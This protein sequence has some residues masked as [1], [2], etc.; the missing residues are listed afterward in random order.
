MSASAPASASAPPSLEPLEPLLE[1]L[2]ELA[3]PE[4]V[5]LLDVELLLELEPLDDSVG[6]SM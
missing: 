2:L 3:L 4:L 5:L 1:L 6:S